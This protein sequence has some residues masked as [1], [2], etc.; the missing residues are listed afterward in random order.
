MTLEIGILFAIILLMIIL[1]VFELLSA[2]SIAILVMVSL[3][4]FGFV[5]PDEGISGLSNR[6]TVTVL[7]LMILSVGLESTGVINQAGR[8]I[9]PLMQTREWIAIPVLMFI[10]GAFS[11]FT[12]TTAV[13]IIFM[14]ILVELAPK[15]PTHLSRL[16]IPLSFAAIMGGSCTL[17]GTSTNLLI[18][19]IARDYD[20]AAFGIFEFSH[21]GLIFFGAGILY[22]VLFGRFLLP[23]RNAVDQGLTEKYGIQ[24]FLT[25]VVILPD[26]KLVGK[27]I[28]ETVFFKDDEID[29]IEITRDAQPAYFPSRIQRLQSDDVLLVKG[30]VEKIAALRKNNGLELLPSQAVMDDSRLNTEDM[31]LCEVLVRPNSRLIGK[32]LNKMR[33]LKDYR[34]V[35]LAI[36]KHHLPI[37]FRLGK[38][39]VESGDIILMEVSRANFDQFYNRPEFVVLQ[40]HANLSGSTLK[41]YLASLIV[42]MVVLLAFFNVLP[43]LVSAL[44]GCVAMF[45][46]GCLDLQRAYNRVDWSVFFLLAGVI[47]LGIAMDNTG[48]SQLI[49]T[50]FVEQ[51]GAVSPRMLVSMLFIITALFSAVIS[52]NAT[53]ILLAPIAFS[54]AGNL[55]IDPRPLL[56]TVMFAANTSYISP[57][58]YQTNTLIYGP[59]D[60][61]FTDFVKVGGMLTLLIWGL[62]TWLIPMFYFE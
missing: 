48:A 28:G 8:F 56:L 7:A 40:E 11:A 35:P 49:A 55:D 24:D 2:D 19:A 22:M 30:S 36:K 31:T 23:T 53:A 20:L 27:P 6:A 12:S 3:I 4:L 26:S 21:F 44:V 18:S 41:R 52:N 60:Y 58:G 16:L 1:L 45:I 14:R 46:T 13:V 15:L 29:L 51:F 25:E 17:L 9:L 62:A 50:T 5:N 37:F 34:A 38:N 32:S 59:G 10:V 57:I 61:R 39:K 33:L 42:L 54:I 47:P 43:I